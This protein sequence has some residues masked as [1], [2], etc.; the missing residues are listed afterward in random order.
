[1]VRE[2]VLLK[3]IHHDNIIKC[4]TSFVENEFLYIVMEYAEGGDLLSL[5]HKQKES[6][7]FFSEKVLWQYAW[8][9]CLGL[10][11]IHSNDIIHRDIKT[12]NVMIKNGV[13]KIGD[14]GESR[15][16][17][18]TDYLSGKMVGT[19]MFL[20]PEVIK[21]QNYDH[22]V[23]IYA[24]GCVMYH[25]A[26]LEPPFYSEDFETLLKNIKY[27][28]PKPLL[29]CYS[30]KLK[31][32]IMKL[33]AKKVSNRPFVAEL[34]SLFPTSFRFMNLVDLSNFKKCGKIDDISIKKSIIDK[35]LQ[36][37]GNEFIALKNRQ[38]MKKINF[39][40]NIN[41]RNQQITLNLANVFHQRQVG[42][43]DGNPMVKDNLIS[44]P[45]VVVDGD[46][47]FSNDSD[48]IIRAV[49]ED[50]QGNSCPFK[51]RN[52]STK[53]IN[54]AKRRSSLKICIQEDSKGI[55][56][57]GQTYFSNHASQLSAEKRPPSSEFPDL[58]RTDRPKKES[59]NSALEVHHKDGRINLEIPISSNYQTIRKNVGHHG[60]SQDRSR[61]LPKLKNIDHQWNTANTKTTSNEASEQGRYTNFKSLNNF[62][63]KPNKG[64]RKSVEAPVSE[65]TSQDIYYSKSGDRNRVSLHTHANRFNPNCKMISPQKKKNSKK[66]NIHMI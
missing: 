60:A 56:F 51:K 34:F 35:G 20:A 9:L 18:K 36:E 6:R 15:T 30:P 24:F 42:R 58:K 52:K 2:F 50:N 46:H 8:E 41:R 66:F 13:L 49:L 21:N 43:R 19:P 16:L 32:F 63:L 40:N 57:K 61:M 29:G 10:L 38:M 28:S 3:N 31:G 37:I 25:L 47:S 64:H 33:L 55:E 14:L 62:A 7:K 44:K 65:Y 53:T 27:K 59:C 45:K 23:D 4:Y 39:K 22:R 5:I 17:N 26:A 11:H 48:S 12:L 54:A 1:M